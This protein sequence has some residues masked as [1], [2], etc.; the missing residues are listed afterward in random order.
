L[1]SWSRDGEIQSAAMRRLGLNVVRGSS[2]RGGG[3]ALRQLVRR[4]PEQ[5]VALAVDGPR[6]PRQRVK[7]GAVVARRL[8]DAQLIPLGIAYGRSLE[9][10]RAWDRFQL[11]LPFTRVCVVIGEPARPSSAEL[12]TQDL[13]GVEGR[14]ELALEAWRGRGRRLSDAPHP[15][16]MRDP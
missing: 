15:L 7:S 14:A 11:P 8:G 4:L 1:V 6:G 3:K 9:F 2:S 12:L 10:R 5:D 13:L 16:L